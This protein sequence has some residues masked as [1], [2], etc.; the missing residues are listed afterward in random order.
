M[1]RRAKPM[2]VAAGVYNAGQVRKRHHARLLL[3]HDLLHTEQFACEKVAS[4]SSLGCRVRLARG[5]RT[6]EAGQ[7]H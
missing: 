6:A 2:R 1:H 5:C 3:S 4:F 7:T